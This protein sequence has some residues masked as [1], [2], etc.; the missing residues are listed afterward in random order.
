MIILMR[1]RHLL[2]ACGLCLAA[3]IA[4]GIPSVPRTAIRTS[5][6]RTPDS[7]P[8]IFLDA[9]HGG[10]DGGAVS[11]DGVV[12]ST[13]NLKITGKTAELLVF[14]GQEAQ[15][16]RTGENAIYD[17]GCTTLR[18]KKVSD[19]H[20]RVDLVNAADQALLISIHQ[21]KLPGQP[22]VHGAQVFYNGIQPAS[23]VA[24]AVQSAMNGSVNRGNEKQS[25]AIGKDV[26][27]MQHVNHPAI[28]VECGFLSSPAETAML[29][30]P[31]YQLTVA[32]TIVCGYI[33]YI[34][35]ES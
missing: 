1:R 10:E 2:M 7:K 8:V 20:N 21:N 28:L 14:L 22:K 3:A 29:Q 6:N 31:E 9:G 17:E 19:I 25:K 15:F 18:E 24:E 33:Q 35:K 26:Y 32:L 5:A 12:E 4:F 16:T 23:E 11:D 30:T 13:L 34:T 27:L